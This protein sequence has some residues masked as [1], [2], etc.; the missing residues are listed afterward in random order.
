MRASSILGAAFLAAGVLAL[1][2]AV[3]QAPTAGADP[4]I[5]S[6]PTYCTPTQLNATAERKDNDPAVQA[7]LDVQCDQHQFVE[8]TFTITGRGRTWS[9]VHSARIPAIGTCPQGCGA[10]LD[11]QKFPV[12]GS[13][14]GTD[15]FTVTGSLKIYAGS[16]IFCPDP[17][18]CYPGGT[19]LRTIQLDPISTVL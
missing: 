11:S 15:T 10:L 14:N 6:E 12:G 13:F 9:G 17:Q 2:V 16:W 18:H 8:W 3:G 4:T 19:P 5:T 7:H 1:P